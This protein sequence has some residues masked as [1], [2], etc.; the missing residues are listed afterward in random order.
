M[1]SGPPRNRRLPALIQALFQPPPTGMIALL[2]DPDVV[3]SLATFA[4]GLFALRGHGVL[5]IDVGNS[6][7]PYIVSRLAWPQ[8]P[9]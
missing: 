9:A 3:L 4:A 1:A 8:G 2:R 7:A 6:S 5:L